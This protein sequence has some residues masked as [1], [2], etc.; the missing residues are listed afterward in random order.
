MLTNNLQKEIV[1][2][3]GFRKLISGNCSMYFNNAIIANL[4]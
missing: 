1:C 2:V 3:Y 4:F